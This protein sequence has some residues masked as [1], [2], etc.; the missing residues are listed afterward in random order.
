M[1]ADSA[2]SSSRQLDG[3]RSDCAS[4]RTAAAPLLE[5]LE[6]DPDRQLPAGTLPDPHPGLR[7]HPED[8]LGAEQEPIGAGA[9]ARARQPAALP[10]AAGGDRPH[11][12]D[13]VVD[14]GVEGGEMPA[15]AGRDPAAQGGELERLREMAKRQP[16]LAKLV[17]ERRPRGAG[18]DPRRPRD[19]IHLEH[20]VEATQVDRHRPG[21]GVADSRLD[22]PDH[23][24]P[25]PVGNR[26]QALV[27]APGEHRLDL[28]LVAR[29]G[30][31]IRR[32]RRSGPGSLERRRGRPCRA[33]ARRARAGR[34]GTGGRGTAAARPAAAAARSPRAAPAPRPRW[35]R[36]R[37]ARGP[38]AQP[39]RAARGVS[40]WSSNPQPQCFRRRVAVS[41][42]ERP[43]SGRRRQPAPSTPPRW[44]SASRAPPP[45]RPAP[46]ASRGTACRRCSGCS[47][48]TSG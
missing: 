47:P 30:D 42:S 5:R 35:P 2:G 36:S 15:G 46:R 33:R 29:I 45:S 6:G 4:S 32:A 13:Q 21:V 8:S 39:P 19:V 28:A 44:P 43:A 41:T 22:A 17:L 7:D 18:L 1:S 40:A 9:G 20:A 3:L 34:S 27:R 25:A 11:R 26:R 24:G 37:A 48:S 31:Q 12:L 16:P 10:E 23:A 14:V 38:P